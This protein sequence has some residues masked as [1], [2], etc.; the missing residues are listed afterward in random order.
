MSNTPSAAVCPSV[1]VTFERWWPPFLSLTADSQCSF[2]FVFFLQTGVFFSRSVSHLKFLSLPSTL[3][4]FTLITSCRAKHQSQS[5]WCLPPLG[6][7]RVTA[8]DAAWTNLQRGSSQ[9]SCHRKIIE[10]HHRRNVAS[11]EF[12]KLDCDCDSSLH[13]SAELRPLSLRPGLS[14]INRVKRFEC[15]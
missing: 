8:T 1:G 14:L 4:K 5:C 3:F 6:Q 12:D 7:H 2:V 9:W 10:G 11:C 13:S 15:F